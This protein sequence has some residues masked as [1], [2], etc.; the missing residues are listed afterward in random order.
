M[1]NFFESLINYQMFNLFCEYPSI[2][3]CSK[4]PKY[5]LEF[6]EL[7]SSSLQKSFS[8]D[9]KRKRLQKVQE[10]REFLKKTYGRFSLIQF[11]KSAVLPGKE[12]LSISD[13]MAAIRGMAGSPT[14]N[15]PS[16][17]T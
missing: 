12:T 3:L 9:L 7:Q 1:S 14:L 13:L 8:T 17:N 5:Q 2:L 16:A 15:R 11:L 6:S 10:E 4:A